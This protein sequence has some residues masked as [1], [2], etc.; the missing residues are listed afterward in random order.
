MK[1]IKYVW[2]RRLLLLL[3]CSFVMVLALNAYGVPVWRPSCLISAYTPFKCLGCG[4]S[5]AM[6]ALMQGEW[7]TA[8]NQNPLI[9]FWIP[10]GCLAFLVDFHRYNQLS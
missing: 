4:M 9:F 10:C 3:T 1:I 2:S 7:T 8:W 6:M 5:H